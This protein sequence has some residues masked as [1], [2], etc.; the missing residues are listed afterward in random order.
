MERQFPTWRVDCFSGLHVH[1]CREF[2]IQEQL[3]AGDYLT[4]LIQMLPPRFR[5]C[6][7]SGTWLIVFV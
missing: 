2:Q 6:F 1:D 3:R 4:L 5:G 7:V